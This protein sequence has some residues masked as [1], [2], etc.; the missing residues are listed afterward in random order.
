MVSKA[1]T[2]RCV[3][4]TISSFRGAPKAR[5]RNPYSQYRGFI[6][7]SVLRWWW[8]WIPAL[9]SAFALCTSADSNPPYS[10][11]RAKAV[12]SAGMTPEKEQAMAKKRKRRKK[13]RRRGLFWKR[14]TPDDETALREA[15]FAA[16]R[17]LYIE[18]LPLWRVCPRGFCRRHHCCL[19]RSRNCLTRGWPLLPPNVQTQALALV[20]QGGPWQRPPAT[21]AEWE[22]R[23]FPPSNFVH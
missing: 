3:A 7:E 12:R 20:M 18:S 23:K 10:L 14:R 15:A 4:R 5:A 13:R 22:L 8:L 6:V 9:A 16:I 11:R 21:R 2:Q 1:R 19:E 17:Q